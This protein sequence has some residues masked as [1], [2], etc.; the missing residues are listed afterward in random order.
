MVKKCLRNYSFWSCTY[1]YACVRVCTSGKKDAYSFFVD[2]MRFLIQLYVSIFDAYRDA[3]SFFVD[4]A[5]FL[6]SCTHLLQKSTKTFF[7][8]FYTL[9]YFVIYYTC[10]II[11]KLFLVFFYKRYVQ[12]SRNVVKSTKKLYASFLDIRTAKS[13]TLI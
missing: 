6:D 11:F 3:Y 7:F 9:S 13:E 12:L 2:L 5:R 10:I 1:L 4:L 8:D